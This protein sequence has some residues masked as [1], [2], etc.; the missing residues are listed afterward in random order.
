MAEIADTARIHVASA[1]TNPVTEL[2]IR[3]IHRFA[4]YPF[5]L[6]IGDV[7]SGDG[8]V[9]MLRELSNRGW[10]T[11]EISL[12]WRQH[13]EWLDQWLANCDVRFAVFVDSDVAFLKEGWLRELVDAAVSNDAVLVC[14]EFSNEEANYRHPTTGQAMRL[15]RRPSAHLM[16]LDVPR[17]KDVGVS[18]APVIEQDP[19]LPE[20]IRSFDVGGRFYEETLHRG[21]LSSSM[22]ASYLTSFKHFGGLSWRSRGLWPDLWPGWEQAKALTTIRLARHWYRARWR[23]PSPYYVSEAL[24]RAVEASG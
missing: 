16:L 13:A 4:G 3:T 6:H 10:I 5:Q 24:P 14:A 8:S 17:V 7:G 15:A 19:S 11:L 12:G 18:F 9:E 1:Q 20:G 21:L 22:P 23:H 2:C